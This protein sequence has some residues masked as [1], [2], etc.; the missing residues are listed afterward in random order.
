[1]A[2]KLAQAE[3]IKAIEAEIDDLCKIN[4]TKEKDN[5]SEEEKEEKTN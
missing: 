5:K 4:M 1:L 2:K 3:E